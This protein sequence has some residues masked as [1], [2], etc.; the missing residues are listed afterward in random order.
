MIKLFDIRMSSQS[1]G[2]NNGEQ[3]SVFM[4]FV[5]IKHDNVR[6]AFF[7]ECECNYRFVGKRF[8]VLKTCVVPTVLEHM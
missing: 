6:S 5:V 7:E 4:V 3:P 8:C 1:G 2:C